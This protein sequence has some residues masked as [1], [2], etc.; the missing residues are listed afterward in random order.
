MARRWPQ[1]RVVG[2][3]P[4]APALALARDRVRDA[5]LA[6]RVE[7]REQAGEHLADQDAFD[8]AWI[9]GA[10]VPASALPAVLDRVRAALR[11]GGWLLLPFVRAV[12]DPL[13]G[14][15]VRLRASQLG[16]RATTPAAIE[17]LLGAAGFAEIRTLPAPPTALS[18]M[19]VARRARR[20]SVQCSGHATTRAPLERTPRRSRRPARETLLRRRSTGTALGPPRALARAHRSHTQGSPPRR[21]R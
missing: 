17:A 15:L 12:D 20:R 2:I 11:R 8:L 21:S 14:A 10:F 7:L 4:W 6:D 3:D 18:G 19:A 1:L 9:P 5:G 13:T 16:G